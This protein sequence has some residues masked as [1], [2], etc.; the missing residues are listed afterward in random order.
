MRI[1]TS[2]EGLDPTALVPGE[3]LVLALDERHGLDAPQGV[4]GHDHLD[5]AARTEVDEAS[6]AALREWRAA[7]DANLTIDGICLPFVWE[8]HIYIQGLITS[9]RDAVA[10][11]RAVGRYG[12]DRVELMD[13][14]PHTERAV[15]AAAARHGVPVT[16]HAGADARPGSDRP[17][18]VPHLRTSLHGRLL[19]RLVELGVPTRLRPDCLLFLS[20]WPLMPLLDRMLDTPGERPAIFASFRPAGARR[21]LRA[22]MRGGWIGTPGPRDRRRAEATVSQAL[23]RAAQAPRIELMGLELGECV[24][25]RI[26]DLAKR[27]AVGDVAHISMLRRAFARGR[28]RTVV[29]AYDIEPTARL[30][31]L[32]ARDVGIHTFVLQHGAV[33]LPRQLS[34]CAVAAEV[35]VWAEAVAP[36]AARARDHVH[37]VGYPMPHERAP[38]RALPPSQARPT[39]LVLGQGEDP[40]TATMDARLRLH[41]YCGAVS[42]VLARRPRA[43]VVLRPHP[44]D[45]P[46]VP[47]AVAAR[48]EGSD[49]TVDRVTDILTLLKGSDLCVGASS[50][51]TF[52]AALAGAPVVVLNLSGFEWDWPLDESSDVPVAHTKQELAEWI[53]AWADGGVLPG[54]EE[55]VEA[56]G[57][58]GEDACGRVAELL[59]RA[60]SPAPAMVGAVD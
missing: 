9:I 7:H 57:A 5:L 53:D 60:G 39:V 45:D 52:Q 10:V 24:H 33:L 17:P 12:S 44:S 58:H 3:D 20:Y 34:D 26:L 23:Q 38:T 42:A 2:S 41:H 51:A 22:A 19:A 13:A 56:L 50:T 40:Y 35:A 28:I 47:A 46:A 11:D 43:R 15:R 55:L 14:D 37:V 27:R 49:V 54:R 36:P 32:V 31:A 16:R 1:H 21:T 59:S 48:F 4:Q 18:G 25:A 6:A 30:V 8:E 29:L